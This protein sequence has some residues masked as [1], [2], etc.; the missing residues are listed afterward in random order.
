MTIFEFVATMDKFS[1]KMMF[2]NSKKNF[3]E[4]DIRVYLEKG[5]DASRHFLFYRLKT[6]QM[7]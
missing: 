2:L 6:N 5:L 4:H 1:S 3:S 7:C